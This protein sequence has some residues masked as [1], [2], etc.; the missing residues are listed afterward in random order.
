MGR[1]TRGRSISALHHSNIQQRFAV[2]GS[3]KYSN[4][5]SAKEKQRQR[6]SNNKNGGVVSP[7]SGDLDI[8][9]PCYSCNT[10]WLCLVSLLYTM[11]FTSL[12]SGSHPYDI[13]VGIMQFTTSTLLSMVRTTFI[14]WTIIIHNW[15]PLLRIITGI[16]VS[17]GY[18]YLLGMPIKTTFQLGAS[19]L[20][21]G[22]LLLLV[23]I[24]N[25]MNCIANSAHD[26]VKQ[27]GI[28]S[29][30]SGITCGVCCGFSVVCSTTIATIRYAASAYYS[31]KQMAAPP[32]QQLKSRSKKRTNQ[33]RISTLLLFLL[34][35]FLPP[36]HAMKTGDINK[37]IDEATEGIDNLESPIKPDSKRRKRGGGDNSDGKGVPIDMNV[38]NEPTDKAILEQLVTDC[39]GGV[40]MLIPLEYVRGY[41]GNNQL[42]L[43]MKWGVEQLINI[44]RNPSTSVEEIETAMLKFDEK[45]QEA[46]E[47]LRKSYKKLVNM[48]DGAIRGAS[49]MALLNYATTKEE[50]RAWNSGNQELSTRRG[51]RSLMDPKAS[52][53]LRMVVQTFARASLNAFRTT[54]GLE[55]IDSNLFCTSIILLDMCFIAFD[56]PGNTKAGY[57]KQVEKIADNLCLEECATALKAKL[58]GNLRLAKRVLVFAV[59]SIK[60]LFHALH[61]RADKGVSHK[62]LPF[63][64]FS[65]Y[66]DKYWFNGNLGD[67][68]CSLIH[69]MGTM[70]H[71]DFCLRKFGRAL[72]ADT[73]KGVNKILFKF[74]SQVKEVRV[75]MKSAA[76]GGFKEESIIDD[77]EPVHQIFERVDKPM[78]DAEREEQYQLRLAGCKKGGDEAARL[79]L[80]AKAMEKVGWDASK[81]LPTAKEEYKHFMNKH[82]Y[83]RPGGS[84]VLET[85]M[86]SRLAGASTLLSLGKAIKQ[87]GTFESDEDEAIFMDLLENVY[88]NDYDR[89]M[90]VIKNRLNGWFICRGVQELRLAFQ[91]T[92]RELSVDPREI[93]SDRVFERIGDIN[94]Q[95]FNKIKDMKMAGESEYIGK[96]KLYDMLNG[97]WAYFLNLTKVLSIFITFA[98]GKQIKMDATFTESTYKQMGDDL[99]AIVEACAGMTLNSTG[100]KAIGRQLLYEKLSSFH[101]AR[102]SIFENVINKHISIIKKVKKSNSDDSWYIPDCKGNNKSTYMFVSRI[103]D[104]ESGD[105]GYWKVQAFADAGIDLSK[106]NQSKH[107]KDD[108]ER[109]LE[110]RESLQ[111]EDRRAVPI[112]ERRNVEVEEEVVE[113]SD[114]DSDN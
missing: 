114:S 13:I 20:L 30:V 80:L 106:W 75:A 16:I 23:G 44:K 18:G 61:Y 26:Y 10:I 82:P 60:Y 42:M 2:P 76:V 79:L 39:A 65:S 38:D 35:L 22:V 67:V 87:D 69:K 101:E 8:E 25:G 104:S 19:V 91:S 1:S 86:K 113:S 68:A 109:Q 107:I 89:L 62:P 33:T 92:A 11:V 3:L 41:N 74:Y 59:N 12:A 54:Y 64:V 36:A 55:I 31:A 102:T 45:I 46:V 110:A 27:R 51:K 14:I 85:K 7:S 56:N 95:L 98:K 50:K 88:N 47:S 9:S 6:S 81:L 5:K 84:A 17:S 97:G 48:G 29:I 58:G 37:E 108:H 90:Q 63:I 73:I 99:K 4:Q 77:T 53:C 32:K 24:K 105:Y 96:D 66:P 43:A 72:S 111:V 83:N 93:I 34:L 71:P 49:A 70:Y 52:E 57:N 78:T 28:G 15:F 100:N 40:L 112:Q 21:F 103:R 94:Q